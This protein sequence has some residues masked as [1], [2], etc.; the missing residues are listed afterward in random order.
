MSYSAKD[1]GDL[2]EQDL[3]LLRLAAEDCCNQQIAEKMHRSMSAIDTRIKNLKAKLNRTT[4][5]GLVAVAIRKN[6]I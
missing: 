2:D 3:I 1:H 5:Q 6:L 4:L